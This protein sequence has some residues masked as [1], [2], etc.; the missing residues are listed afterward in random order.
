MFG[1]SDIAQSE[2]V[3]VLCVSD[4]LMGVLRHTHSAVGV[5]KIHGQ[6]K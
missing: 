1:H 2:Q 4:L 3:L 6:S 5:G